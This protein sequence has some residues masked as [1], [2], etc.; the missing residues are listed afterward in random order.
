MILRVLEEEQLVDFGHH[1]G[2][3][4]SCDHGYFKGSCLVVGRAGVDEKID[5]ID[6]GFGREHGE[7]GRVTSFK[8]FN[9]DFFL[10][11]LIDC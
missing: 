4:I 9:S 10:Q 8:P 3:K 6:G 7:E 2:E 1:G 11:R 5:D